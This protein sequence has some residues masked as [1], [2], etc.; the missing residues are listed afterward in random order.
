MMHGTTNIKTNS[1]FLHHDDVPTHWS[2]LVK[3]FSA[4]N[5]VT[6]LTTSWLQLIFYVFPRLKSALNDITKNVTDELKRLSQ[7]GFHECSQHLYTH[8]QKCI[9][10]QG[11]YFEGNVA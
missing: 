2:V 4:K 10:V 8:W 6:T 5:N 9:V 11:D 7:N 1:W 3:D